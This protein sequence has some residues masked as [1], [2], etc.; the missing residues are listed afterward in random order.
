MHHHISTHNYSGNEAFDRLVEEVARLDRLSVAAPL[1]LGNGPGG[2]TL[3]IAMP[4]KI[5]GLLFVVN[6]TQAG[7]ANGNKTT[8]ATWTYNV[9]DLNHKSLGSNLSP[10]RPR[11]WGTAAAATMGMGYHD[12]SGVF[13]LAEAWETAGSGGCPS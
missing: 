2:K 3:S 7:G 9:S 1:R 6:L 12:T 4:K 10:Q 8:A 13:Y 5:P 11:A